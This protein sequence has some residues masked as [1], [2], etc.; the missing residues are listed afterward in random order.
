MNCAEFQKVLPDML[1]GAKDAAQEAH[2]RSCPACSELVADLN[3]ITHEAKRLLPSYDPHPRVWEGIR[4]Q[5]EREGLISEVPVTPHRMIS[6][7]HPAVPWLATAAAML[8]LAFGG[9]LYRRDLVSG[10]NLARVGTAA[11]T[12][13]RNRGV[14][15]AQ[16]PNSEDEQLVRQI[17]AENPSLRDTYEDNLRL[18][19]AYISDAE[20]SVQQNPN[21]EEARQ[22]LI[23]AYDQKAM[24]YQMG[25]SR[26]ME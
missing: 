5:L 17:A 23:R 26:S 1:E 3:F 14:L 7:S 16:G 9:F 2:L 21:D 24:V 10:Q 18:V 25:L 19:N 8:L 4:A 12:L 20:Q 15:T 6:F 11:P 22:A 13:D